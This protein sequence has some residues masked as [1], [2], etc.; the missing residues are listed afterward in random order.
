MTNRWTEDNR[1]GTKYPRIIDTYGERLYYDQ[2][3]PTSSTITRAT[4]LENVSFLRVK[5][6]SL[7]YSLPL[8]V[9]SKMGIS[10][11][12]FS[13]IL[14]NLFTITNYS[15]LDPETPGANLSLGTFLFIWT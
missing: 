2:I 8:D 13:F 12:S 5:N 6:M 1:T 3:Y 15:G 14:T 9:V 4:M 11:L 7:S 10:S